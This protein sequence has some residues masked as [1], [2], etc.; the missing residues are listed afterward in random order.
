MN[1]KNPN[2]LGYVV[3][4]DYLEA[5][6][7][8]DVSD[9]IQKVINE[10][11]MRTIYFPDGE[12]I[13][14]KPI[15]TSANPKNGVAIQLS[16]YA[17]LKASDDWSHKEAMVRLGA[18]EPFNTIYENG[19]N[20][21]FDGGIIDGN[22]IASGIA[23]ESGRE[24]VIR[25]TSI[26]HTF[27]GLHIAYGANNSSSDADIQSVNIVGNNQKDSIG[28]LLEGY[29]N[30]L[31]NLRIA[32][33]Q[34]GVMLKSGGNCLRNV[35]PLFIYGYEYGGVDEIDYSES[36]AFW[37]FSTSNW[38]DYCYSD[39]MATG[40]RMSERAKG[41]YTN[42]FAM[43]YSPSGDKEIAFHSEC[44]FN[45]S[46]VN[47][48]VHFRDDTTVNNILLKVDAEGGEGFIENPVMRGTLSDGQVYPDYLVGKALKFTM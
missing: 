44:P 5:N 4:T 3:V 35:H 21:Y 16:N 25:N 29:D 10:N 11:P 1:D 14:S 23:I 6:T 18:A 30:T 26:K 12:Y 36:V 47:P 48:R 28:V 43:W 27:I 38:Y 45:A 8:K 42:C 13:L 39:Q 32:A 15:C 37:D 22:M 20:Y 46:I 33:V 31:T 17:V 41:I 19:S 2:A 34:T 9:A 40:F 7:G 24:T